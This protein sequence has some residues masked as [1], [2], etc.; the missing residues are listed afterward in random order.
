MA[1][2]GT[3]GLSAWRRPKWRRG[4]G[5]GHQQVAMGFLARADGQAVDMLDRFGSV[6]LEELDRR[7]SFQRRVDNKYLLSRDLLAAAVQQLA[8][9]H[10]VLEIDGRRSFRYESVYFDTPALASF[11]DHVADRAPRIKVRSRLYVDSNTSSFELKLKLADG[12]TR[13]E[14]LDQ[15]TREHGLLTERVREFLRRC[16]EEVLDRAAPPDLE[17]ML[18]TSFERGTLVARS[19]AERVTIDSAVELAR[20]AGA[21][22][23]LVDGLMLVEVKSE[24]GNEVAD[25]LLRE[26]GAEPVAISKYRVGIGLLVAADPEPPLGGKADEVF[27]PAS[28]I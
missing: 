2:G 4:A 18:V 11:H 22:V 26:A 1:P 21:A 17:P 24:N 9:D 23:R 5:D 19:G 3:F 14:A 25:A 20:P 15:D 10:D 16:L 27:R 7:A 8:R 12:E 28:E 6:S 13:K